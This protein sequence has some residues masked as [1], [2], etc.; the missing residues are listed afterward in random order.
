MDEACKSSG[1]A[2]P[3]GERGRKI[4]LTYLRVGNNLGKPG[5]IPH[6]TTVGHPTEVKG[7]QVSLEER[8]I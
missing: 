8:A 5:L 2:I 6:K 3:S 1:V 4:W 7:A